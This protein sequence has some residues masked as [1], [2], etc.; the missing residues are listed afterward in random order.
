V[1]VGTLVLGAGPGELS[2]LTDFLPPAAH[3]ST[4][5]STLLLF[6]GFG[7][8]VGT[9]PLGAG[10]G[11]LSALSDFLPPAL[12]TPDTSTEEVETFGLG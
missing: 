3:A 9:W 7:G 5:E 2:A 11:E 6:C 1:G 8:G 10:P 12:D 4:E